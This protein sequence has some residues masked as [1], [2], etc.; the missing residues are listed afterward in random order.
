[1]R[2]IRNL[3][4]EIETVISKDCK[5]ES[6]VLKLGE[7]ASPLWGMQEKSCTPAQ[8]SVVC[9]YHLLYGEARHN[10]GGHLLSGEAR[11]NP[12]DH[13]LSEEARHN[14]GDTCQANLR[15]RFWCF[16]DYRNHTVRCSCLLVKP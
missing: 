8:L 4:R 12:G 7:Q 9:C 1:M 10:P 11:H 6:L 13:L 15:V 3:E 5:I 2:D 14:L 16:S